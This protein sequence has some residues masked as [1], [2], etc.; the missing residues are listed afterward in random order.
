MLA[1]ADPV[2][3]CAG[4]LFLDADVEVLLLGAALSNLK[5]EGRLAWLWVTH[6]DMVRTC[7]AEEDCEGIV[8]YALSIAGVEAAAFLREL[9]EGAIRLSLR[10][11]GK[12][13][14]AAIAEQL[15]GGGHENAAGCHAGW[16]AAARARGDSGGIA[17]QC[18]LPN[19]TT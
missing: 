5:R 1:G 19:S 13:D 10:S 11:K 9:P 18:G 8:N 16:P 17:R 3:H 7:A 6:Q 12:V 15:G 4:R 14:V 2:A